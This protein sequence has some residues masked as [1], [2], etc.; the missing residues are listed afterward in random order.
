[1]KFAGILSRF[2]GFLSPPVFPE[3][4]EKTRV[5]G[6]LNTILLIVLMMAVAFAVLSFVLTLNF[7]RI[8]IEL[9]LILVS[10]GMLFL[11]RAG[12]VRLTSIVFS[13]ALL[14]IVSLGTYLSGGFGGT[15]MSAY[16]GIIIITGL[17]LGNWAALAYALIAIAFTGWMV[18]DESL[19]ILPIINEKTDLVLLWAEFA[20][21]LFGI[22]GLLALVMINLKQSFERAKRKEEELAYRLVESEQLSVWAQEASDFKSHLLARVSHELRT[23]L[24]VIVG[25]AEMLRLEAY[26]SVTE[27][28][29]KLLERIQVNSKF[30][31]TTF[32][33]LLEQSQLD[34]EILPMQNLSFSPASLLEK[35]LPEFRE[36]AEEKGLQ[37]EE[38]IASE[39]PETLW[40]VPLRV[41]Q[42]LYHLVN[43]AIKFTEKGSVTVSL[44]RPDESRWAMCVS[45]TGIGIPREHRESI[46]EPFRQV[47]ESIAREY[48]GVGLGLSIV[49]RLTSSMKGTIRV[50]SE[51]GKGS[52]FTV[53]LPLVEPTTENDLPSE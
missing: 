38:W 12:F 3:D 13:S 31:E 48:G 44:L 32:S 29:K 36:D 10:V 24:G 9:F 17:L 35:V 21:V 11:M 47:D 26:G 52:T 50:D 25:M 2:R 6:F 27:E 19:Y 49:K 23:P 4:D 5:A 1:M 40:G 37:F 39:L 14:L 8:F 15:T 45:D 41:Q 7:N 18:Y 28:Q 53:K 22:V 51:P 33:E 30:L 34:R 42:I 16:I 43:N 46:F 20:S